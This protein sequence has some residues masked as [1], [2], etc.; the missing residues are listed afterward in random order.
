[1]PNKKFPPFFPAKRN[2]GGKNIPTPIR[3]RA[4]YARP[5]HALAPLTLRLRHQQVLAHLPIALAK[6]EQTKLGPVVL[7]EP[8]LPGVQP[9]NRIGQAF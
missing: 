1:M 2:T 8:G 5:C 6:Q 7:L 4:S 3:L 9:G